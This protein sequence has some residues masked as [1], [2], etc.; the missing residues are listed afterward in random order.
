MPLMSAPIL[1]ASV[2]VWVAVSVWFSVA[3]PL[4]VS[5]PVGASFTSTILALLSLALLSLTPVASA[6]LASTCTYLPTSACVSVKLLLVAPLM[7]AQALP[8][9]LLCHW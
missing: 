8:L 2:S 7:S 6:Y 1:S 3:V 4:I 9:L 5:E